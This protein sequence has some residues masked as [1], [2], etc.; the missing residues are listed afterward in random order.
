MNYFP[1]NIRYLRKV[2][3]MSQNELADKLGYKSFTTIQ[4]WESKDSEPTLSTLS[5]LGAIFNIKLSD[6]CE[7]DL[8]NNNRYKNTQSEQR[9]LNNYNSTTDKGKSRI[10]TTSE[11]M[12]ELYPIIDRDEMLDYLIKNGIQEA[13][14]YGK[15]IND[16]SDE[17][18][19]FV[20]KS[21][22]EDE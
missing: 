14:L 1:K 22:R 17:Q 15:N 3:N 4:K 11:E 20:Y 2:H 13:A 6:L 16:L 7:I 10:M 5:K 8:E 18:L 19:A 21:L 9:L 12:V